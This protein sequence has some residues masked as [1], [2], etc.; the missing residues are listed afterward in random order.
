[1]SLGSSRAGGAKKSRSFDLDF[2]ICAAGTTSFDR[3]STSF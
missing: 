3:R 1:L 2:F